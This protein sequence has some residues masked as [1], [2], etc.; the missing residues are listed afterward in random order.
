MKNRIENFLAWG[1]V[2]CVCF[3]PITA[4]VL[5]SDYLISLL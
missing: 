2:A 3:G 5:L 4:A 1:L